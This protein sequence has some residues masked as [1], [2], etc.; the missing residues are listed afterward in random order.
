MR[1]PLRIYL[2]SLSYIPTGMFLLGE[3]VLSVVA[4]VLPG[5]LCVLYDVAC[6]LP[7]PLCVPLE[8]GVLVCC[9]LDLAGWLY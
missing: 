8:A 7:G 3:V 6:V 1:D 4:C 5:L 9:Y 2:P